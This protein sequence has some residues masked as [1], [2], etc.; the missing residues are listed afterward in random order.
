MTLNQRH[1]TILV[2]LLGTHVTP[3]EAVCLYLGGG[4]LVVVVV[5]V[6]GASRAGGSWICSP[7]S[8]LQDYCS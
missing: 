3:Q 2:K 4:G 8:A 7:K 5:V 6:L 1:L